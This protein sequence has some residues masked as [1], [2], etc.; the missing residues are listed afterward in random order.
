MHTI[1]FHVMWMS[2]LLHLQGTWYSWTTLNEWIAGVS[3][4]AHK[5]AR[6]GIWSAS[7][8]SALTVKSIH[9]GPIHSR[10]WV[11]SGLKLHWI[12]IVCTTSADRIR[13]T[14]PTAHVIRPRRLNQVLYEWVSP[15]TDEESMGALE[16]RPDSECPWWI[17]TNEHV[18]KYK[19]VMT[20]WFCD[21]LSC[22]VCMT[23]KLNWSTRHAEVGVSITVPCSA[24]VTQCA[25]G[26]ALE[27]KS[28]L[29]RL[30][31]SSSANSPL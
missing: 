14:I 3:T 23:K 15:W 26:Y 17:A 1:V 4:L 27:S 18:Y 25:L 2:V 8:A 9:I 11:G 29:M 13:S 16:Q 12:G 5:C 22:Y 10:R 7:A 30:Q 28:R 20:Q 21:L 31:A 19:R 24:D 6:I